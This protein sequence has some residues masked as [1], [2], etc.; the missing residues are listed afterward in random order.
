MFP[1]LCKMTSFILTM[2]T[3]VFKTVRTFRWFSK[4]P[5]MCLLSIWFDVQSIETALVANC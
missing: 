4:L 1:V 5:K 2:A 3:W